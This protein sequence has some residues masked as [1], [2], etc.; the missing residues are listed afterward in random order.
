MKIFV[1]SLTLAAFA[2]SIHLWISWPVKAQE[3]GRVDRATNYE[4]LLGENIATALQGNNCSVYV[5]RIQEA[6]ER[7][8]HFFVTETRFEHTPNLREIIVPISEMKVAWLS[9]KGSQSSLDFRLDLS[10]GSELI[11][12]YRERSIVSRFP[13]VTSDKKLF[14]DINKSVQHYASYRQRPDLISEIPKL[15]RE[16][17]SNVFLSYLVRFLA[18]GVGDDDP[19]AKALSISEVYK[20][21]QVP[22]DRFGGYTAQLIGYLGERKH[23]TPIKPETKEVVF[24]NVIEVATSKHKRAE[25]ATIILMEVFNKHGSA[26]IK[27]YM[28]PTV[29]AA[30][31]ENLDALLS[32]RGTT[33]SQSEK[34][35]KLLRGK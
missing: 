25:G 27:R 11:I 20:N 1:T 9:P 18:I 5:G 31:R 16:S 4:F 21:Y 3:L 8:I 6:N 30:L 2:I 14:P 28:T 15:V 24:R 17:D 7:G 33:V 10:K 29:K 26:D 23:R 22:E 13:F 19:D 32:R 35:E 12:F 34:F